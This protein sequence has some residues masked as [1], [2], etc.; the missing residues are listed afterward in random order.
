MK[1]R[2]PQLRSYMFKHRSV[3]LFGGISEFIRTRRSGDQLILGIL[4]CLVLAISLVSIYKLEQKI[5]VVEPA[6]GG[7]L[8]EGDIGAPRFINP[9]LAISDTDQD[10]TALTYAGLM[11]DGPNGS[12]IPVLAQSYTISP[13]GLTY[14]FA[15]KNSA[16]FSDGT[17]VTANDVVFTVNK[18]KDTNL[19]S[20]QYANWST[21]TATAID[22]HT[23]QFTLKQPYS[24]FL[25][26]ATLGILPQHLWQ[27]ITDDEFPFSALEVKPVGAGPF[28]ASAVTQDASGAITRYDLTENPKF[29]SGRPYL[30]AIHFVFYQ[31]ENSLQTAI[32]KHAVESGYGVTG[33]TMLKAPY[34][35]VFAVFFNSGESSIL[36]DESVRQALSVSVD[37][38]SIV[39][40]LL[41]GYA[42]PLT[43]P[44]PPGSGVPALP[45]PSSADAIASS[46]AILTADGWSYS[47]STN[48]WNNRAGDTLSITLKTANVPELKALAEAIQT[49]WKKLGISTSIQLFDPG[50][51]TQ[52]VIQ[53]RAYQALL[54][55][56][57]VGR[58]DDLYD[59]WDS[60]ERTDPGLNVAEY[61]NPDVDTLLEKLRTDT[62]PSARIEDLT[63]INQDIA[64]DYPAAF[65]ESPDFVYVVPNN[66]KGVILPEI[67]SPSDRFATVSTW[68]R[69]TESV[70]PFLARD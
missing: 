36:S 13:D 28:V 20:P 18:A 42:T 29:V 7:S 16:K 53:P 45:I 49:D 55:G 37:R 31:D 35:R 26:D 25:Q 34:A 17:P 4:G 6:Y 56:M 8:T 57:V 40:D 66:L 27:D 67:T 12:V 14:T 61:S 5:L 58:S 21:V 24:P 32:T 59:F 9:L 15:I 44:V 11:G 41:G 64:T 30:D 50:T 38:N 33:Q 48:E 54:F 70:W 62:D 52:T 22:S 43:G 60:K 1:E 2:S 23:V 47:S 63:Q 10:L 68:Y 46:T 51:L 19:K 3:P 69:R 39:K 65:I